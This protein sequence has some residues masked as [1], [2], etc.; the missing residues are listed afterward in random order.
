MVIIAIGESVVSVA[1]AVSRTNLDWPLLLGA[2]LG[3]V[4]AIALWRTY[5]NAIAVAVERALRRLTGDD[6][7]RM[8]RDACTYL[9]L[10]LVIGIVGLAVG[11]REMLDD[12]AGSGFAVAHAI[13]AV[14]GWSLFGGGAIYLL[15]LSALRWRVVGRPS[16]PRLVVAGWLVAVGAALQAGP[17]RPL[18]DVAAVTVSFIG[19]V[20]V[21]ALRY[22][23]VTRRIRLGAPG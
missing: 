16:L 12:V 23:R 18:V 2:L 14:A 21:D 9:H 20:T 8:A 4:L 11:L 13:P 17:A 7:T 10:G 15:V 6:R 5:F 1:V 19:L 3:I 22:G